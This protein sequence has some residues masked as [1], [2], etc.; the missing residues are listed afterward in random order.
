M[1]TDSGFLNLFEQQ[2][3]GQIDSPHAFARLDA[4]LGG[5]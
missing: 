3:N 5:F 2:W 4:F 1:H